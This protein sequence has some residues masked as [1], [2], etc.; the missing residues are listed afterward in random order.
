VL[1]H[2]S[3]LEKEELGG[4][5]RCGSGDWMMMMMDERERKYVSLAVA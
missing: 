4:V 1:E 2:R 5:G 3:R